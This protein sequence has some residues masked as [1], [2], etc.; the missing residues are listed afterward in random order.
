[1]TVLLIC[2]VWPPPPP[3]VIM[4]GTA[5]IAQFYVFKTEESVVTCNTI[6]FSELFLGG[7]LTDSPW[8]GSWSD[9][10]DQHQC[11]HI[12]ILVMVITVFCLKQKGHREAIIDDKWL[13]H[14]LY[15]VENN[16]NKQRRVCETD[17]A[18]THS[19]QSPHSCS[20]PMDI[21]PFFQ[22]II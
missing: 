9:I 8:R 1:M 4:S 14:Q 15:V 17:S 12:L 6:M 22:L 20:V 13:W 16:N 21:S 10:D 3:G 19:A 18:C 11:E 2:S 5:I 7:V